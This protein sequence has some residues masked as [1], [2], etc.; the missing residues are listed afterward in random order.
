MR[1]SASLRRI[2]V[3]PFSSAF[4]VKQSPC[5][6]PDNKGICAGRA[7]ARNLNNLMSA[8]W[9][10][11]AKSPSPGQSFSR[12]LRQNIL[13]RGLLFG[14]HKIRTFA[15]IGD[16]SSPPAEMLEEWMMFV[17]GSWLAQLKSPRRHFP[18]TRSTCD[19]LLGNS[20]VG[21]NSQAVIYLLIGRRLRTSHQQRRV[22]RHN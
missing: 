5:R 12:K 14:N 2:S 17:I 4:D 19:P 18:R 21:T 3:C 22:L 10:R 13:L 8:E 11:N 15:E 16:S 20:S 9:S 1:A 7:N 6:K